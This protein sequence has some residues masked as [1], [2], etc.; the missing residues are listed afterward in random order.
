[1]ETP[2]FALRFSLVRLLARERAGEFERMPLGE[3]RPEIWLME[4]EVCSSDVSGL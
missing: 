3:G 1:M 2:L 4:D